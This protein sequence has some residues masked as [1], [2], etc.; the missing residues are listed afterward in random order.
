[1]YYKKQLYESD[2]FASRAIGAR[3]LIPCLC[4]AFN[5]L[6]PK[7]LGASLNV[8]SSLPPGANTGTLFGRLKCLFFLPLQAGSMSWGRDWNR[9]T[10]G[11]IPWVGRQSEVP[12]SL[13]CTSRSAAS[14]VLG[15]GMSLLTRMQKRSS[16][17]A[18]C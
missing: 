6:S 12:I 2:A 18:P 3:N 10:M 11:T 9:P 17:S 15:L 8:H 7:R 1:M 13:L 5:I 16:P 4:L 14:P